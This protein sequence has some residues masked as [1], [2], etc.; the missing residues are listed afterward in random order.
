M[1]GLEKY[2]K[3]YRKDLVN[4]IMKNCG[5]RMFTEDWIVLASESNKELLARIR[6][7]KNNRR[8]K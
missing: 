6:E 5:D 1:T 8:A 7:I 3:E 4:I 2:R